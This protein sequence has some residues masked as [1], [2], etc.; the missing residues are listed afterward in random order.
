MDWIQI[1]I[2]LTPIMGAFGLI[3]FRLGKLTASV[4][5]LTER[6]ANVESIVAGLRH[7]YFKI[8]RKVDRLVLKLKKAR[9]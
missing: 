4:D 2:M 7:G 8:S 1:V 3:M 9:N 5:K 6:I